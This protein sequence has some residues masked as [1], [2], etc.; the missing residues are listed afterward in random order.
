MTALR[1]FLVIPAA[2]ASWYAV[3]ICGGFTHSFIDSHLCPAEDLV[4]G[5]CFNRGV[6]FLLDATTHVFVAASAMAVIGS[7][8]SV[9]PSRKKETAWVA[10]AIGAAVAIYF[11]VRTR[12]Y[13]LL[14]AALVGGLVALAFFHLRSRSVTHVVQH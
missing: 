6:I 2:I 13:T 1:W 7:A 4:S 5:F 12:N 9:A 14:A 11:G 3:F 8:V 10:F